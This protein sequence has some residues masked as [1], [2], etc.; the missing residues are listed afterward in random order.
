MYKILMYIGGIVF[1]F[2]GVITIITK[3]LP[4]AKA[5]GGRFYIDSIV[6]YPIG[7]IFILFGIYMIYV[8]LKDKKRDD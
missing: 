8:V 4:I 5:G 7:F 2:Q 6:I 3:T 1:I